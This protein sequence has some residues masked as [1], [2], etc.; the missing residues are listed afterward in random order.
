[1]AYYY[2]QDAS[3]PSTYSDSSMSG[4]GAFESQPMSA[5]TSTYS[6]RSNGSH[7]SAEIEDPNIL[8]HC[9]DEVDADGR[10][11]YMLKQEYKVSWGFPKTIMREASRSR[12]EDQYVCIS[13]DCQ[14]AGKFRRPADLERH[15]RTVHLGNARFTCFDERC[16]RNVRP[17]T[18]EDHL[19]EHERKVHL[20]RPKR[21]RDAR[22]PQPQQRQQRL[23]QEPVAPQP[24]V[25]H[26]WLL[27]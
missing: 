9:Y 19:I 17:F 18:R 5:S 3:S 2:H 24:D 8:V 1:M 12:D 25:E 23:E 16:V 22:R 26:S 4:W 7:D 15:V 21:L 14:S 13:P 20:R 10:V 6:A 27:Y 11:Y